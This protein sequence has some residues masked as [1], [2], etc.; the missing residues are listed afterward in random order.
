[1]KEVLADISNREDV[2]K[3][4][5]AFYDKIRADQFLGP[6]FNT[7]ITDWDEHLNTLTTFWE[8]SLFLKTKYYGN[9]LEVHIKVDR[10]NE[11]GITQEHFGAW[12]N[13]WIRTIDELYSGETAEN[14]KQRA[15]KMSTFL[16]LNIYKSRPGNQ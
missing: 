9:P 12:L 16:Y 15:R 8:S 11:Y 6:F 5:S 2:F 7:R 10:E 3:L 4:V 13:I 14:A 1:M